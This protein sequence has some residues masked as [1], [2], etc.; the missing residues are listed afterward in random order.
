MLVCEDDPVIRMLVGE[1]L[2]DSG[3]EVIMAVDGSEALALLSMARCDTVVLDLTMPGLNGMETLAQIR[4]RPETR[5]LPV[6]V[7]TGNSDPRTIEACRAAGASDV[8]LKPVGATVLLKSILTV[9]V[10]RD[11]DAARRL[12]AR[13]GVRA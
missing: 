6:I 3:F 9:L 12:A 10:P 1:V 7:V 2:T 13:A 4:G 5:A 8:L 11:L